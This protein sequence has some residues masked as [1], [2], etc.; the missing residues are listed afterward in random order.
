MILAKLILGSTHLWRCHDS[1]RLFTHGPIE[2]R[3]IRRNWIALLT[4]ADTLESTLVSVQAS[5]MVAWNNESTHH[6][7]A[8]AILESAA[9]SVL[10][11]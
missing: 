7:P 1:D 3:D 10:R 6:R 2:V 11:H 9:E 8:S 4:H 5:R